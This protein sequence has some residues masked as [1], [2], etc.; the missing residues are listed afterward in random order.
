MKTTIEFIDY[1][2][3]KVATTEQ[4]SVL[5]NTEKKLINRNFE[6]NKTKFKEYEHYI[7]I[8]GSELKIFKKI[9]NNP[10]HLKFTSLLYLWTISGARLLAKSCRS[11][12]AWIA[13]ENNLDGDLKIK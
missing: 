10:E 9:Q 7:L 1:K 4:L 5:F 11:E 12:S 2:G 6:R 3:I 13:Y 8:T